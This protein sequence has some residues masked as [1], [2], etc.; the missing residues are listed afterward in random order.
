MYNLE[1]RNRFEQLSE[2]AEGN[3]EKDW[4][5]IK[6]LYTGA[7]EATIG[8]LR[9]GNKEWIRNET[10]HKIQDR[11]K[12]KAKIITE[13]NEN[14]QNSLK[15]QYRE[16]DRGWKKMARNDKRK[17]FD[18]LAAEAEEAAEVEQ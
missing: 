13:N 15:D 2:V 18:D 12:L 11:K 3:V 17:Y 4:E 8:F 16:V 10:L 5:N 6:K 1:V 9:H 14:K 7:A